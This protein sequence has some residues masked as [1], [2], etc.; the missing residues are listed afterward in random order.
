MLEL[1]SEGDRQSITSIF[2]TIVTHVLPEL[3]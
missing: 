2:G 1:V 3:N